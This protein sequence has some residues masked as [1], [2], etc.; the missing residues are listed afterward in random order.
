MVAGHVE[1]RRAEAL[2]RIALHHELEAEVDQH[3]AELRDH[4]RRI[5]LDWGLEY[6]EAVVR[7][8]DA[9]LRELRKL[10][11]RGERNR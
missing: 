4:Y 8:A 9:T 10:E 2:E 11:A 1:T 5:V 6:Y 3:D 7:W